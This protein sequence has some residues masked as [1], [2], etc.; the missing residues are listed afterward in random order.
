M[1]EIHELGQDKKLCKKKC[2]VVL[3][4]RTNKTGDRQLGH[5]VNRIKNSMNSPEH[6]GKI[7]VFAIE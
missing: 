2:P 3:D 5:E 1:T 6:Y 4:K 7:D